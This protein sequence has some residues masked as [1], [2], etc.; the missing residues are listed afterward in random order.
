M[1]VGCGTGS[2]LIPIIKN[3]SHQIK[4]YA[5]DFSN[6][7]IETLKKHPICSDSYENKCEA[8]IHDIAKHDIPNGIQNI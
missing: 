7:A 6:T 5:F 4:S 2:A 3:S 1:A 8:F